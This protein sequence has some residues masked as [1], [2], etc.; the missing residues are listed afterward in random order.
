[1][2]KSENGKLITNLK[3]NKI[4]RSNKLFALGAALWLGIACVMSVLV[5]M[6]LIRMDYPLDWAVH[7]YI[8]TIILIASGVFIYSI[9]TC[10]FLD[11]PKS[12]EK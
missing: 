6:P 4:N 9:V 11:I 8:G 3:N 1:M 5:Y 10:S 7:T 12:E 2:I